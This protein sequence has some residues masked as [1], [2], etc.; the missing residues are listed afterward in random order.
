M[1]MR[2]AAAQ[3][4]PSNTLCAKWR[5]TYALAHLQRDGGGRRRADS[6]RLVLRLVLE[7]GSSIRRQRGQ[8]RVGAQQCGPQLRAQLTVPSRRRCVLR[9]T[10][11]GTFAHAWT[12]RTCNMSANRH[13][14]SQMIMLQINAPRMQ[15]GWSCKRIPVRLFSPAAAAA[16]TGAPRWQRRLARRRPAPLRAARAAPAPAMA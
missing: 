2:Q 7:A 4:G 11:N 14:N 16:P 1:G 12:C 6:G 9:H 8:Q 5:S 10:N 3:T 15:P 13:M